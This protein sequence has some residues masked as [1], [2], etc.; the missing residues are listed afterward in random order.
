MDDGAKDI[1]A[2]LRLLS[3]MKEQGITDV[4]AT[5]HFDA[6]S[7]NLDDYLLKI[8]DAKNL[9]TAASKGLDLPTFYLGSEVYY[10]QGIGKSAGIRALSLCGSSYLLLELPIHTIDEKMIN[11]ILD[12]R[13]TL[14][15]IPIIA[16]V[17]R[18]YGERGF[19]KLCNLF[20]NGSA[21]AQV[22][23]AS[24][25]K[26]SYRKITRKLIKSGLI[27]FIATDAHSP[28][29]RPPVMDQAMK[30]ITTDFGIQRK[31]MFIANSDKLYQKI[32][33]NPEPPEV[34]L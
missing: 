25:L 11:D 33:G 14:G 8:H 22:N 19:K 32:V 1:D 10:F 31:K 9:L 34:S 30:Q 16:H 21:H 29:G 24:V 27:T 6:N 2:S 12:L 15:I 28:D 5:P 17:E 3:M 20:A 18:L 4:I 26:G 23:A 7:D 13:E